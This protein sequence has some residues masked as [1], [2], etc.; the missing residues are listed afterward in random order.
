LDHGTG[1]Q[2]RAGEQYD[3]HRDLCH[4]ESALKTLLSRAALSRRV[5]AEIQLANAPSFGSDATN[6]NNKAT[7]TK[8]RA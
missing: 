4:D 6:D 2:S 8:V 3:R 1:E 7:V 5:P